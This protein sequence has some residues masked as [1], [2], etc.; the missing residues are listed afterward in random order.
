MTSGSW[1]VLGQIPSLV[2]DTG[3]RQRQRFD[4]LVLLFAACFFI[5]NSSPVLL[6][7]FF[8]DCQRGRIHS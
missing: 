7:L 3:R 6:F 8:E 5:A 1:D 4:G 2:V